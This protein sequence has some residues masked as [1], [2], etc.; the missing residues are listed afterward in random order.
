MN[1]SDAS[2]EK[3]QTVSVKVDLE[4]NPGI[5][6]CIIDLYYDGT[7]F[8]FDSAEYHSKISKP[9]TN[10]MNENG[11]NWVRFTWVDGMANVTGD[12]TFVDVKFVI[13]DAAE[14]KEYPLDIKYN[15]EDVYMVEGY[16]YFNVP[17]SI[18]KGSITVTEKPKADFT[19]DMYL[20]TNKT[21]Y[22]YGDT[23]AVSVANLADGADV[24]YI[25]NDGEP[26]DTVNI[27]DAGEYTI[28]AVVSK[29][30]YNDKELDAIT[31][32]IAKKDVTI[33]GIT[34]ADKTYDGTANVDVDTTNVVINGKVEGDDLEAVFP[35]PFQLDSADA[36]NRSVVLAGTK[37]DGDAADNYTLTS[38]EEVTIEVS[39]RAITVKA[40]NDTK[41][42]GNS[43]PDKFVA[44][45]T[46]GTL[47]DGQDIKYTVSRE[48]GEEVGKYAITPV[49]EITADD[50]DV[51][52][53]YEISYQNGIFEIIDKTLKSIAVTTPPTDVEYVV[54]ETLDIT[55]MVVTATY[56]NGTTDSV[57]AYTVPE[58]I[59]F[60]EA[61]I[62]EKEITVKYGEAT[63]TFTVTVIAKELQGITVDSS[64]AK[65][66]Y[67]VG[68]TFSAAGLL[69]YPVYNN[70]VEYPAL[71]SAD[72]TVEAPDMDTV[73]DDAVATVTYEGKTQT[74]KVVIK[75]KSLEKQL[76][77]TEKN[78]E[79][80]K[81]VYVEGKT[82]DSSNLTVT[83]KYNN[84]DEVVV[85]DFTVELAG[86]LAVT[87]KYVTISWTDEERGQTATYQ[88]GI[89]VNEAEVESFLFV[90]W[91]NEYIEDQ[92][93]DVS[94]VVLEVFYNNGTSKEVV[95]GFAV[96]PMRMT[97]DITYV[98]VTYAGISMTADVQVSAKVLE[99]IAVP[100]AAARQYVEGDSY[101]TAYINYIEATYNNGKTYMLS[102]AKYTVEPEIMAVDTTELVFTYT[103]GDVTKT[104]TLAV[105]VLECVATNGDDRYA[106]IVDALN[107][108]EDEDTIDVIGEAV[109]DEDVI[110]NEDITVDVDED[111]SLTQEEDTDI[112]V[113]EGSLTIVNNTEED[114][115]LTINGEEVTIAAGE[116]YTAEPVVEED[117]GFDA[118]YS[119]YMQ[120]LQ[121]RNRIFNINYK[122][123]EGGTVSG[124]KNARIG[125]TV[126]VTITPDE[127][128]AIADVLVNGKSVGAVESYKIRN[129]KS[130][131][132][133]SAVFEKIAATSPFVDVSVDAPYFDAVLYVYNNGIIN[134]VSETEM[135]FA[136]DTTMTRAMFVTVLGR[137]SGVNMAD[138]PVVTFADCEA[139]SWYAPYVE[140]AAQAG[141]VKGYSAEAF[142]PMD[143]ITVEQAAVILY[144][145]IAY[146]GYNTA[147]D[148]DLANYADGAQV[149][150]WAAE[151]MKWAL[152]NNIYV[153][154]TTLDPQAPAA[155][156]LVAEMLYNL[157]VWMG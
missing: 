16:D 36:G 120:M 67:I 98:T 31:V 138:Y 109:I 10:A 112:T 71:D 29:D 76:I 130:N 148:A 3:G 128:Y 142:G 25:V 99:D 62:G 82:F 81:N 108:A 21:S 135:V 44:T 26:A 139:G 9:I 20:T 52:A 101:K 35:E 86:S 87:D 58:K 97:T 23:V 32:K 151:Q 61:D 22:T 30:G 124:L 15:P 89:T 102:P 127:G 69:V 79:D 106:S 132:T 18:E 91:E 63:A 90:S 68:Q 144:R 59:Q 47:A 24:K 51:T 85:T 1:I 48:A 92:E 60:T 96:S 17:F 42:V 88:Y 74:Y 64:K 155:R 115:T 37:L 129:I 125:Q 12:F 6:S 149:S 105:T 5:A 114:I 107:D 78:A 121:W 154:D 131:Q 103:E 123:T 46:E 2:G 93:F 95:S 53:N 7:A 55:G 150:E 136:P 145:Y 49:A 4:N 65:T 111:A 146:M 133:V 45:I 54:D 118:Y 19:E 73:A 94:S 43:D 72:Y 14:Y 27:K 33:S 11:K 153:S 66:E 40:E 117:D 113:S 83:A 77:V 70:N 119:F 84:G 75:D 116:S 13:N 147:A 39:K 122:Q 28:S 100:A 80:I 137:M 157:S 104:A 140:W 141:I 41:K 50:K 56:D 152:A 156:S 38:V 8:T 34:A 110:I 143:E 134:G 126:T 57:D